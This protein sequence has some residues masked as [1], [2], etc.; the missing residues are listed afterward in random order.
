M[1]KFDPVLSE[2]I[3]NKYLKDP[4]FCDGKGSRPSDRQQLQFSVR[5]YETKQMVMMRLFG[6]NHTTA[7]ICFRSSSH[8]TYVNTSH[9]NTQIEQ[10]I[11][12]SQSQNSTVGVPSSLSSPH[13][14]SSAPPVIGLLGAPYTSP[15]SGAYPGGLLTSSVGIEPTVSHISD[16]AESGTF[17]IRTTFNTKR[18]QSPHGTSSASQRLS[19]RLQKAAS[20]ESRPT[21]TTVNIEPQR[22]Y[23]YGANFSTSV[24]QVSPLVSKSTSGPVIH[25]STSH[26]GHISMGVGSFHSSRS[27][28]QVMVLKEAYSGSGS[29]RDSSPLSARSTS[30]SQSIH[31]I[32]QPH[33][34]NSPLATSRCVFGLF[35]K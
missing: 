10:T 16:I 15:P 19:H 11:S 25:R 21:Y 23:N 4:A 18:D 30:S 6:R 26:G 5:D 17:K 34:V 3:N 1:E 2:N 27:E 22:L 8:H 29:P 31:S 20:F 35:L 24:G 9:F 13:S 32:S 33:R 7:L 28:H 14:V 12:T